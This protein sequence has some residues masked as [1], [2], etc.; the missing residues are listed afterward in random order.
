MAAH[1]TISR[2]KLA[3][4]LRGV[5]VGGKNTLRMA[6]LKRVLG[7]L[8]YADVKTLLN[9][10]N[11][12]VTTTAEPAEVER[13]V[14]SAITQQLGLSVTVMVRTH[15]QLQAV[16]EASPFDGEAADPRFYAVAFLEKS[17][18]DSAFSGVQADAYAPEKWQL[19]GNELFILY[20]NGQGRTKIA[21]TF[22]DKQLQVASTAR[23]WNTVLKLLELTG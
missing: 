2:V 1:L 20:A 21:S 5:N 17:P 16:V 7:E 8:G 3:V 13:S 9:S 22:F 19:E 14:A 4:L 15:A 6:D 12:V 23:N 18:P 11:A 10:G